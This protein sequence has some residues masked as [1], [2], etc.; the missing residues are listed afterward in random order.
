MLEI[1]PIRTNV[2]C[3]WIIE[4]V[5]VCVCVC[6][7]A[8]ARARVCFNNNYLYK[9]QQLFKNNYIYKKSNSSKKSSH[10]R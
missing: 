6:L 2:I 5:C 10:K 3:A 4:C 9:K 7:R 8:R 1:K